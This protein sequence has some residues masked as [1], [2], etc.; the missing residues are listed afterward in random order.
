M[1]TKA[2][3]AELEQLGSYLDE[4][5]ALFIR[6]LDYMAAGQKQKTKYIDERIFPTVD[7]K[8][9]RQ[10]KRVLTLIEDH[11]HDYDRQT[12]S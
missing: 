8:I 11:E 4:S 6:R 3:V 7:R 12:E 10:A 2:L 9:S 1:N 5:T